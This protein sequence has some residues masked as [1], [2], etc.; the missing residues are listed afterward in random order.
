MNFL[1]RS[2]ANIVANNATSSRF[3][4]GRYIRT[5]VCY[6]YGI[7]GVRPVYVVASADEHAQQDGLCHV[8]W[9]GQVFY[10]D[11]YH[12]FCTGVLGRDL[13][14]SYLKAQGSQRRVERVGYNMVS[15]S[16]M[17]SVT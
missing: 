4:G 5:L 15:I 8:A 11:A 10:Q 1:S 12:A 7:Y 14:A 9:E 2:Q 16:L 3:E 13:T 6:L 17:L